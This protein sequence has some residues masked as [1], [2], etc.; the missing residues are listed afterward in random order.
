ME[1][2]EC[3]GTERTE[4]L[5]QQRKK[6]CSLERIREKKK[7]WPLVERETE[8]NDCEDENTMEKEERER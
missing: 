6:T 7:E 3:E 4:L 2:E 1:I 5:R 8:G